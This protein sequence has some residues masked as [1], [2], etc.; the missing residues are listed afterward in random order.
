MLNKNIGFLIELSRTNA[1]ERIIEDIEKT[2]EELREANKQVDGRQV[3]N[4]SVVYGSMR[5]AFRHL[6]IIKILKKIGIKPPEND[7]I[8]KDFDDTA[9]FTDGMQEHQDVLRHFFIMIEMLYAGGKIDR[10]IDVAEN[11]Y[12]R[13]SLKT[14]WPIIKQEDRRGDDKL[15]Y[16]SLHDIYNLM[17]ARNLPYK[18]SSW[19]IEDEDGSKSISACYKIQIDDLKRK[20]GVTFETKIPEYVTKK[21]DYYD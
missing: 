2:H 3:Y 10:Y 13:L 21:E 6:D 17:K 4:Y 8:L 20:L 7:D 11:E 15:R 18:K 19:R 9:S 16:A 1:H 14:L 5:N 12:I